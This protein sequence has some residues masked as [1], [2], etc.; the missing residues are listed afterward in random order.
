MIKTQMISRKTPARLKADEDH[1]SILWQA[2]D[3]QVNAST[4][5]NHESIDCSLELKLYY[6]KAIFARKEDPI[7]WWKE[8]EAKYPVL[9]KVARKYLGIQATSVA[10]ERVFS[11]AGELISKRRSRLKS[12]NVDILLFLNQNN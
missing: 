1:D 4:V 6:R 10:S 2:F 9:A 3:S 7:R 8:H 5:E 12:K 11:K